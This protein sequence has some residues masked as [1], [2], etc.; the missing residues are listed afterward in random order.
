MKNRTVKQVIVIRKDLG[1][2][3]G[4]EISQGSHASMAFMVEQRRG[5]L[6]TLDGVSTIWLQTGQTKITTKVDNEDE[7]NELYEEAKA[8]GLKVYLITDLGHTEFN[9]VQTKTALA[10]GPDYAD[11]IDKITGHLKLY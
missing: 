3:R 1:M 2:R 9:G 8:A 6:I 5:N 4:K 7:L 10:I 11:S